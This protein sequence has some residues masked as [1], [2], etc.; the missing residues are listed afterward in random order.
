VGCPNVGW[1]INVD[2]TQFADGDHTVEVTAIS[3]TG[4][5]STASATFAIIN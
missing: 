5:R 3:A 2:T 4:Q 1:N